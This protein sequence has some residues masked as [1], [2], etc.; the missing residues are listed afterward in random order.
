MAAEV[1]VSLRRIVRAMEVPN[2]DW[3]AYLHRRTGELAVVNGEASPEDWVCDCESCRED[4]AGGIIDRQTAGW[5]QLCDVADRG[6]ELPVPRRLDL[7]ERALCM[8][9]CA[10]LRDPRLRDELVNAL[11]GP[12]AAGRFHGLTCLRGVQADWELFRDG[13]L[14]ALAA[15]W[16]EANG[17]AY[18]RDWPREQAWRPGREALPHQ[19]RGDD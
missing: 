13:A 17:V 3:R 9:F 16:L 6:H 12:G 11:Q 4:A 2:E 1:R 8:E 19:P 5:T 7:D 14:A 15:D 18:V 10:R